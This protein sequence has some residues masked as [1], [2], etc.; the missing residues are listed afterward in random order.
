MSAAKKVLI[1]GR[2]GQLARA[3]ATAHW[4]DG[5]ATELRGRPDVDLTDPRKI[6]NAVASAD[7]AAVV[8]AAAYTAVDRAEAEPD[9]AYAVNRD[10]PAALADACARGHIPLVHISTDYVFDGLKGSDYGEDDPVAPLSVYGASKAAGEAEIRARCPRHV[11]VRTA[12]LFSA[13]GENFVKTMLRLGAQRPELS[14]VHDQNGC[15]TAATDLAAAIVGIVNDLAA[16]RSDGY[17]TFHFV[18]H[19]A[20]TWY[21]FATAIFAEARARG[22]PHAPRLVPIAT[23]EYPQA[24]RRPQRTVLDAARIESIYGI[25]PRPWRD[26]LGETLD[27]L[28]GPVVGRTA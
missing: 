19:P 16:G 9:A 24:A 22:Y 4:P 12:W 8:N 26:G 14:I 18:G 5:T 3:L 17:G 27:R 13:G 23:A 6:A 21:G 10:G 11:I 28:V 25:A 2:S 7:W 15:P 20:T 1:V